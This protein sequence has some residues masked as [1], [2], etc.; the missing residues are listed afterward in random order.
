MILLV[1]LHNVNAWAN[2]CVEFNL[3]FRL[4]LI[5]ESFFINMIIK[6]ISST[7]PSETFILKKKMLLSEVSL[8]Y[9]AN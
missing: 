6:F 8:V 1:Q 5:N 7:F 9:N 2:K 3:H 4:R